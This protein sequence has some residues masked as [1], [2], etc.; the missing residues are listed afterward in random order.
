MEMG[1]NGLQDLGL[2]FALEADDE[3]A[4]AIADSMGK[5][6]H[7]VFTLPVELLQVLLRSVTP[8]CPS[9]SGMAGTVLLVELM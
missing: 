1:Q 8:P 5:L 2:A 7:S 6:L 9:L 3:D 4:V